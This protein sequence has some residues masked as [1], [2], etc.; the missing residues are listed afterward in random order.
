MCYYVADFIAV[1]LTSLSAGV[2]CGWVGVGV[3]KR[4]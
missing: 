2:V 4:F 1:Y 3:V